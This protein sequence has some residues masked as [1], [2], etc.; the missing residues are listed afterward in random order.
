MKIDQFPTKEPSFK[1]GSHLIRG[2]KSEDADSLYQFMSDRDVTKFMSLHADKLEQVRSWIEVMIERFEKRQAI[3]WVIA[4]VKEGQVIGRCHYLYVNHEHSRGEI[5]YCLTKAYWGQGIT[6]KAITAIVKYGFEHLELNRIEATVSSENYASARVL[7][8]VGFVK[9]G[10]LRQHTFRDDRYH[11]VD[12][13]S[14]LK[15][16]WKPN[17]SP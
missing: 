8:K 16:D 15:K 14:F 5:G 7:E 17:Q 4:D 10:T 9:E 13:F 11:D 12:T 1:I 3:Y 6:T 2:L